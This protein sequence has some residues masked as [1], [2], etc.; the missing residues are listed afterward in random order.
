MLLELP[1]ALAGGVKGSSI[2]A[3]AESLLIFYL[4]KALKR[5]G[6]WGHRPW[7]ESPWPVSHRPLSIF[8]SQLWLIEERETREVLSE[9]QYTIHS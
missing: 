9:L 7:R 4:A 5:K 8:P 1:P 2:A 6:R 3:L